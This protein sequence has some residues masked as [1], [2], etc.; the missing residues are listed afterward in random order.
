M[1]QN[2]Y[3]N[4]PTT[5]GKKERHGGV[6]AAAL[7]KTLRVHFPLYLSFCRHRVA[8]WQAAERSLSQGESG[9]MQGLL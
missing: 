2:K 4:V 3:L 1:A 8:F 7:K 6:S 5:S 9:I